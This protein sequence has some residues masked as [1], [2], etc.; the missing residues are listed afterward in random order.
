MANL[1]NKDVSQREQAG[2]HPLEIA[3]K[4]RAANGAGAP[5]AQVGA[6]WEHLPAEQHSVTKSNVDVYLDDCIAVV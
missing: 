6:S 2:E 5:E 4:S 1:A 3:S